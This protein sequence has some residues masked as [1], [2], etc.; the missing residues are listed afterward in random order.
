MVSTLVIAL[1]ACVVTLVLTGV[2]YPLAV[3]GVA[4][5]LFPHEAQGSLVVDERGREVGSALIAQGFTRGAYFQPR[6]SA[7]GNG[8]DATASSGSNLGPTSQK[9]RDRAVA[10]AE[11]LRKENPDAPG[12]VPAELVTASGSGL[13]PHLSPE[14]ARWQVPRVAHARGVDPAR[15]LAVVEANVEGRTLGVLGEPRVN[16]LLLNLAL[17]RQFGR[18]VEPVHPT[19]AAA[20]PVGA[21]SAAGLEQP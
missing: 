20:A 16:A 4:Q 6:P 17:D 18:A 1:R 15:V 8:Y 13:D 21:S 7:A 19:G 12:P 11:R 3:T 10:D 2:L 9:L 5:V 14:A